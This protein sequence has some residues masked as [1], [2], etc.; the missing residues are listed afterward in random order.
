MLVSSNLWTKP[1]LGYYDESLP[2]VVDWQIKWAVEHG[3]GF[4]LVDWYWDAGNLYLEHWI[5]AFQ[6]AKHRKYLKWAIMW[7]NHNPPGA[8]SREDWITVTRHWIAKYLKTPEYLQLN[9]KPVIF[10]WSTEGLRKDMKGSENV[11][12]LFAFS[13]KMAKEAGLPGL[14][15]AA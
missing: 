12:E 14:K 4:F 9:G 2:E 5:D 7:A 13:D 6:K 11:A 10:I 15:K 8:H 1:A 3:I